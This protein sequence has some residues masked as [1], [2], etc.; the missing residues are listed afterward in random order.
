MALASTTAP[1]KTFATRSEIADHYKSDWHKYNL[2]RREA[3]LPLLKEEEF[4]MRLEAAL[5]LRKEKE[6]KNGTDHIK[7]INSKKNKNKINNK[8][9]KKD[10][11][12]IKKNDGDAA[13]ADAVDTEMTAEGNND[14][15]STQK[16]R[17]P[18]ALAESQ[19]NPEIDPKQSL[20]NQHKSNSLKENVHYMQ[21]KFGFFLPDRECLVDVE[22][23][24]GYCHEKIKL[25]HFCL[26]CEQ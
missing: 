14:E 7:D 23:L 9:K 8:S 11:N 17:I 19:E 12:S 16:P 21:Q 1:G 22:G 20:F 6:K 10:K 2:K 13:A 26:Y 15:A 5:A 18:A 3:G 25:G 4:K 24:L